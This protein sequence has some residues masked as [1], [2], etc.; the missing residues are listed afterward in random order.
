M[1]DNIIL[2]PSGG[3]CEFD[4]LIGPD[5]RSFCT[6]DGTWEPY[7]TC[8]G[9]IRETRDGCKE[10]PGPFGGPRNRT[11]EAGN[12]GRQGKGISDHFWPFLINFKA[13]PRQPAAPVG[14]PNQGR[15]SSQAARP[16]RPSSQA[17]RPNRPSSNGRRPQGQSKRPSNNRRGQ[18]PQR[19]QSNNRRRPTSQASRPQ[20]RPQKRPQAPKQNSRSVNNRRKGQQKP[21]TKSRWAFINYVDDKIRQKN[22]SKN[23]LRWSNLL[24]I[25]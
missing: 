1:T 7:P 15:P 8:Q 10:C 12:G 21:L 25:D 11:A 18:R 24:K 20:Q 17:A 13:G 4:C 3:V 9:D 19:K 16:N 5:I 14:R 2:I 6:K 23:G 22:W